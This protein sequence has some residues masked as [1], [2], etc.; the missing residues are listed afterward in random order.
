M[1]AEYYSQLKE[2]LYLLSSILHA[3]R[4]AVFTDSD[5][6]TEFP[7]TRLGVFY[8]AIKKATSNFASLPCGSQV[9]INTREQAPNLA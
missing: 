8:L 6:D 2:F 3:K 5:I 7:I 4:N 1:Q 9:R